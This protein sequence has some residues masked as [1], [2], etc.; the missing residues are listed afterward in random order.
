M[1]TKETPSIAMMF[2]YLD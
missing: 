2:W 1:T